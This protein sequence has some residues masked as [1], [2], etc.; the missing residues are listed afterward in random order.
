MALERHTS[1]GSVVGVLLVW[2]LEGRV[3]DSHLQSAVARAAGKMED[4]AKEG[5]TEPWKVVLSG[6]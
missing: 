6:S 5:R 3:T 2:L 4:R 1:T